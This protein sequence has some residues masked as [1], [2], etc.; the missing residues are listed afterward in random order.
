[1]TGRYSDLIKAARSQESAE[2][3]NQ[4]TRKLETQP[5]EE[6]QQP[7]EEVNL[8]IKVRKSWRQHWVAESKRQGTTLTATIVEALKEKFG[9]PD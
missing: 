7:E 2:P 9:L 6:Q 1:M 5:S 3:E 8:S 4:K